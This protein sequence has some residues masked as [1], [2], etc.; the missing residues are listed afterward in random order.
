MVDYKT[1]H[2]L[3]ISTIGIYKAIISKQQLDLVGVHIAKTRTMKGTVVTF[4]F[5]QVPLY[6]I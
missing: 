2:Q 5:V 1:T 6:D 4:R 3:F